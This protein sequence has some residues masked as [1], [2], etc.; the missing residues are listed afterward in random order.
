MWVKVYFPEIEVSSVTIAFIYTHLG[1]LKMSIYII[2]ELKK[3]HFN[4]IARSLCKYIFKV[5]WYYQQIYS[6]NSLQCVLMYTHIYT[7]IQRV[8]PSAGQ[9]NSNKSTVSVRNIC[10]VLYKG[11]KLPLYFYYTFCLCSALF[12]YFVL[13]CSSTMIFFFLL[14]PWWLLSTL[15]SDVFLL[16]YFLMYSFYST[17]WWHLSTLLPDNF[18]LYYFLITSFYTTFWWP[19]SA[20]FPATLFF[21][22]YFLLYLS[23]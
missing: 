1:K 11:W 5:M 22:H 17:F 15:L 10:R 18:L 12:F 13:L 21:L 19:S 6:W 20:I 2:I 16:L 4:S 7:H 9:R 14:L 8:Q 3:I 23:F